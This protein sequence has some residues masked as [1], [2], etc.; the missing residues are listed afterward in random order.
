MVLAIG[1]AIDVTNEL[2][3]AA[4]ENDKPFAISD[5][6]Y[7]DAGLSPV[8]G[9]S[10]DPGGRLRCPVTVFLSDAA[11]ISSPTWTLHGE[12]GRRTMLRRLW[13]G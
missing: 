2:R 5:R 4:A 10:H 12:V 7:A 3:K 13:A 6:V 1:D 11:P 8:R 9:Q